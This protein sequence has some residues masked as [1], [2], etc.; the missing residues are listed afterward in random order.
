M[1]RI[2]TQEI[3]VVYTHNTVESIASNASVMM[4][5]DDVVEG[6]VGPVREQVVVFHD[7]DAD[8]PHQKQ[9]EVQHSLEE[10]DVK[11]KDDG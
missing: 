2:H 9:T 3:Q 10:E 4:T 11:G 7:E 1:E 6:V 8:S 5:N